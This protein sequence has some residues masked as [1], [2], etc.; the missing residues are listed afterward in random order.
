MPPGNIDPEKLFEA[1]DRLQKMIE[2]ENKK[3]EQRLAQLED[4]SRQ[5][6]QA[7]DELLQQVEISR[8]EIATDWREQGCPTTKKITVMKPLKIKPLRKP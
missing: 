4:T 5:L 7:H 3:R 2:K 8:E 1:S 6:K